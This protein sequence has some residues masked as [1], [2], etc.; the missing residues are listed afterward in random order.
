MDVMVIFILAAAA[1]V[2][3]R[4][5]LRP[6]TNCGRF[7][8]LLDYCTLHAGLPDPSG[9]VRPIIYMIYVRRWFFDHGNHVRRILLD[10]PLEHYNSIPASVRPLLIR[11]FSYATLTSRSS[12][13]TTVPRLGAD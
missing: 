2:P 12:I 4:G 13:A 1:E 3:L 11:A 7:E 6:F 10:M 8:P 5:Y 9:R